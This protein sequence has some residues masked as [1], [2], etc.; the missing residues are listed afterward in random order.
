MANAVTGA[1]EQGGDNGTTPR[2][3]TKGIALKAPPLLS[4]QELEFLERSI[5]RSL[6]DRDTFTGERETGWRVR[7]GLP[8]F[9][10]QMGN[11]IRLSRD[12]K[13]SSRVERSRAH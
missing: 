8:T 6:R 11:L 1:V 3:N 12:L 7:T 4:L 10:K 2:R 5:E 13:G 9:L